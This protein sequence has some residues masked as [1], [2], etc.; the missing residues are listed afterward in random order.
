[1]KRIVLVLQT[2]LVFGLS[3]FNLAGFNKFLFYQDSI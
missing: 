3:E 1:M 2:K